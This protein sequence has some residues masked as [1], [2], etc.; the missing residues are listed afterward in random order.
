VAAFTPL[1]HAHQRAGRYTTL[2]DATFTTLVLDREPSQAEIE[3]LA[4]AGA[5]QLWRPAEL[6]GVFCERPNDLKWQHL[7]C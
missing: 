1:R 4:A 5:S 7:A 3:T 6:G 2:L